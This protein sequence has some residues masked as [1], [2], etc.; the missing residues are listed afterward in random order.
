MKHVA[1]VC[2]VWKNKKFDIIVEVAG[3]VLENPGFV[4]KGYYHFTNGLS[5]PV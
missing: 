3:V 1:L 5:L 4:V 2:K